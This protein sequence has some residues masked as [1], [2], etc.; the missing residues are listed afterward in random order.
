MNKT[1][2]NSVSVG[3]RISVIDALRGFALLGIV[4]VHVVEQYLGAAPPESKQMFSIH[5]P[6]DIGVEVFLGIFFRGKF[7]TIFSLLFGLSF[8]I[9]MDRG[10]KKGVDFKGRFIW[11]LVILFVIGYVH[12]LFY[13]G[14]ILTVYAILGIFLV[15]FYALNDKMLLIAAL[16]LV[17]GIPRVLV[18]V[19]QNYWGLP[20]AELGHKQEN[21][22]NA[23]Y[24]EI[25]SSGS[26]VEVFEV[27]AVSGFNSKM[28]FQFG[29]MGRGYQTFVLFLIG[30]LL[31]RVRFFEHFTTYNK[32]MKR[33]LIYALIVM[34]VSIVGLVI[35]FIDM[36]AGKQPDLNTWR[37]VIGFTLIDWLNLAMTAM[38]ITGFLLLYQKGF[39]HRMLSSLAP[40][41][42]TALTNYFM[43][44]IIGTF[45]LYGFGLGFLGYFGSSVMFL[46]GLVLFFGQLWVSRYWLK[47]FKYGPLEWLWRSATYLKWQALR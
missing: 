21:Q 41:G 11:R 25:I 3:E 46:L 30:L 18:F 16:I 23:E 4:L 17:T 45:F 42:Q 31:G 36:E 22:K 9:Q 38:I 15:L 20:P 27:N 6:V 13:R 19:G 34:L 43:Q 40:Y 7:F 35:T 5:H 12:G 14:D 32:L 44:S 37:F 33:V 24:F 10:S 2:L 28:G 39:W 1:L 8:F 29:M 26:L 47:H